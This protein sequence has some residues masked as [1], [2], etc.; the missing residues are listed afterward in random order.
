MNK[1]LENCIAANRAI[2]NE[3]GDS[4]I[5]IRIDE[6]QYPDGLGYISGLLSP[7]IEAH[8]KI[9]NSIGRIVQYED[10]A[11]I[12][13]MQTAGIKKPTIFQQ[14][15]S[16]FHQNNATER[17]AE[18]KKVEEGIKITKGYSSA[19]GI[20][21]RHVPDRQLHS[22]NYVVAASSLNRTV[23]EAQAN[24]IGVT[25]SLV[26]TKARFVGSYEGYKQKQLK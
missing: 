24:I 16:V 13:Q 7:I 1:N 8:Q 11:A 6:P 15:G 12:H 23:L 9:I 18:I 5:T 21:I 17:R 14:I 10:A 2:N 19:L 26:E 20:D 22:H 3:A 25:N 4:S